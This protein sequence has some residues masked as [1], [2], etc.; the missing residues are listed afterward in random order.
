MYKNLQVQWRPRFSNQGGGQTLKKL[1]SFPDFLSIFRKQMVYC[2][3]CTS[4]DSSELWT[5]DY[6]ET[7]NQKNQNHDPDQSRSYV[8]ES[9]CA[10][11]RFFKFFQAIQGV[12][13]SLLATHYSWHQVKLGRAI[14]LWFHIL[15]IHL[16]HPQ[17]LKLCF[18]KKFISS[19]FL[20]PLPFFCHPLLVKIK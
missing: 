13:A 1:A 19:L 17:K 5:L 11:F 2:T 9:K 6:H 10:H 8:F 3:S 4:S 20:S 18:H 7:L 16:I 14:S 15:E 12:H